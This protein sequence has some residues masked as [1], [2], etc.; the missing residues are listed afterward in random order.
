MAEKPTPANIAT[1]LR[2]LR[3]GE[4]AVLDKK[5]ALADL[6]YG[7]T[8]NVEA[9][10]KKANNYRGA[11]GLPPL[12]ISEGN[13]KFQDTPFR[14]LV[15]KPDASSIEAV[16]ADKEGPS[17]IYRPSNPMAGILA[18]DLE[19]SQAEY[20]SRVNAILKGDV[21]TPK[22][23]LG[24]ELTHAMTAS[25]FPFYDKLGKEKPRKSITDPVDLE[26]VNATKITYPEVAPSEFAPALAALTRLE[27]QK[28][29]ARIDTPEKFDK[30]IA[31][32]DA[33]S[34]E[35]KIAFRKKLPAEVSRFYGY[36]DTVSDP[37]AED[38][39]LYGP[40]DDETPPVRYAGKDTRAHTGKRF[41][42]VKR[43]IDAGLRGF[44]LDLNDYDDMTPKQRE[45]IKKTL[46]ETKY[47]PSVPASR[48]T[49]HIAARRLDDYDKRL[50]TIGQGY[51]KENYVDK[52]GLKGGEKAPIII[53]GKDRR[54]R[55][56]DISREMIP[57]LVESEES[58]QEA[59]DRR[60]S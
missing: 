23:A 27:Y 46:R 43:D 48:R 56:L 19:P 38:I 9:E 36:L 60:M 59:V 49:R 58:F 52:H 47:G 40:E 45:Y 33:M 24:H 1:V 41:P 7:S 22:G 4:K 11:R 15:S 31:E 39:S 2:R 44:G 42:F 37:K 17:F 53:K 57:S 14:Q 51:H 26:E 55:F 34:R 50:K 12:D 10:L 32:Y 16:A 28:T 25:E 8:K 18:L 5:A 6:G 54:K 29:G 21:R 20:D 13:F 35:E 3:K 30:K